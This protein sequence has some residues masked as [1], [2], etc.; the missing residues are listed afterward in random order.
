MSRKKYPWDWRNQTAIGR[1][2]NYFSE[3]FATVF[4]DWSNFFDG[5]KQANEK[6]RSLF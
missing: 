3:E 6:P 2:N 5:Y 4:L 1:Y